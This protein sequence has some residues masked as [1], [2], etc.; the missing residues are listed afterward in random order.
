M[1]ADTSK[2]D[3]ASVK[4]GL[5]WPQVVLTGGGSRLLKDHLDFVDDWVPD[6]CLIGIGLAYMRRIGQLR[7]SQ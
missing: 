5:R 2:L 3:N 4:R 1:T 7:G 6:L